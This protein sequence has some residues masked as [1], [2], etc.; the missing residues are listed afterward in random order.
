MPLDT[1][2]ALMWSVV[3]AK[4]LRM[5]TDTRWKQ[6]K[7]YGARERVRFYLHKKIRNKKITIIIRK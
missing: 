7:M 2:F 6:S 4:A 1:P 3:D 5:C